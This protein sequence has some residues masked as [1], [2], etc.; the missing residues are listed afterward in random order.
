M[1]NSEYI[2]AIIK[3]ADIFAE[4]ELWEKSIKI[5]KEAQEE[6]VNQQYYSIICDKIESIEKEMIRIP[7]LFKVFSCGPRSDDREILRKYKRL[8]L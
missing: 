6:D 8:C 2:K 1:F 5:Y 7:N 4:H 3:I